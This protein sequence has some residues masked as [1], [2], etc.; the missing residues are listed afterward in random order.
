[1]QMLNHRFAILIIFCSILSYCNVY[2]QNTS[3][4]SGQFTNTANSQYIYL[5]RLFGN[6]TEIIDSVKHSN[7]TFTFKKPAVFQRGFYKLSAQRQGNALTLI[8]GEPELVVKGDLGANGKFTV[9]NSNENAIY[10][11]YQQLNEKQSQ[12]ANAL[13]KQAEQLKNQGLNEQ[14]FQKAIGK[15]QYQFDSLTL[16][17][18]T[19]NQLLREQ[20]TGLFITKVISMFSMPDS[21]QANAFFQTID[22]TDSELCAGD[23]LPSK[24]GMYFQRY[25]TPDLNNW[26]Q[27]ASTLLATFPSGS[28]NKQVL[29][30]SLID[31]FSPYD[32]DFTKS[33]SVQYAKE[34]PKSSFA[35]KALAN[36]PK[37]TLGVGDEAIELALPSPDGKI[38]SLKS[39]RG[40]VV[41]LDFWA[42]WCGPC[43]QENPNVVSA[44]NQYKNKGFTV[45]SVSLDE[46][47]EK[48]KA[49]IAKDGLVWPNHISDLKGWKSKAAELYNVKGIPMTFLLDKKGVIIATNLR[50]EALHQKLQE[51]LK[52]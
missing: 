29:Y 18:N 17:Y 8:L 5:T 10:Q 45:F 7:G 47:A 4:V 20:N 11:A 3:L 6:K 26:K 33:L 37:G 30:L 52:E 38:I 12:Q 1:M 9:E 28:D 14:D 49:A 51:L 41:L 46:N 19:S 32:P 44:Y 24:I 22:L 13:Q 36:A 31:M 15:I 43:R 42:S 35:Q 2:G 27:A 21:T 40:K 16:N 34:Y 39:L 25:V 48:W 23:M 50:G